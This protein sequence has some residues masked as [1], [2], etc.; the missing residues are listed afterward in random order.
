MSLKT[1]RD[2]ANMPSSVFPHD[3]NKHKTES[4]INF[5]KVYSYTPNPLT[6]W[7]YTQWNSI[8]QVA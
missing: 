4:F 6:V 8:T 2:L 3:E 5:R 1:L 7:P